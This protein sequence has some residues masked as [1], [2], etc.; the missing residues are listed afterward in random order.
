MKFLV[1]AQLPR[2]LAKFL[3]DKGHDAVHTLE[4]PNG[5]DTTDAEINHI[6]FAEERV[7][8]SKDGD[9]YDSFTTK[10]EPYKLLHIR[11]GNLSN[12]ALIGLFEKNLATIIAE[13]NSGSVVEVTRS[14]IISIQ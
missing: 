9:F 3:C 1:D 11:T 7:V 14:Y 10:R 12:V 13:L 2:S 6:S 4:L 8:I 5:N